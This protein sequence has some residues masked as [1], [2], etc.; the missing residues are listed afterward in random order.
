[1][2]APFPRSSLH[3]RHAT[4]SLRTSFTLIELLV[5]I[6]IIAVLAA[7]LLPS[8][9]QAKLAAKRSIALNN[10]RQAGLG[11]SMYRNDYNDSLPLHTNSAL[12]SWVYMI[13]PYASSNVLYMPKAVPDF[14]YRPSPNQAIGAVLC[15]D[16]LMGGP[17]DATNGVYRL[18]RPLSEVRN[19]GTTFLLTHA[20]G[21]AS[22][23]P[24]HFD[25]PFTSANYNPPV[26]GSGLNVYFVDEHIEFITYDGPLL[27]KWWKPHP[28]PV[29]EWTYDSYKIFGP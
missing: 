26:G 3:Q 18:H 19:P 1:M 16:N 25:Q 11:V 15:N 28:S 22:W 9:K 17:A 8:L 23:S 21:V 4:I 24:T 12:A 2:N 14:Y 29:P 5:V 13:V 27:S 20:I 7:L 10:L 6:A